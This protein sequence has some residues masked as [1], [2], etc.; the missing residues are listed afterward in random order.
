MHRW[1]E[2]PSVDSYDA[3]ARFYDAVQGDRAEHA[4]YIQTLID[5]HHHAAATVLELGCG[6]GSV[7]KQ[8]APRYR[9]TGVDR[10]AAMLELAAEKLPDARLLRAD[11]RTFAL[12]ES[13][14]VVLCVYDTINH[15][16]AFADWDAVF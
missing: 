3:F 7:M 2:D 14:D 11:I 1:C 15:L 4:A 13:F 10:S 6:T 16:L 12:G 8:L 5:K 9:V